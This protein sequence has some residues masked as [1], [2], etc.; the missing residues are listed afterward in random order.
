MKE[1]LKEKKNE[2]ALTPELSSS[3]ISARPSSR[4]RKGDTSKY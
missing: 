2:R 1:V 3:Y 4:W